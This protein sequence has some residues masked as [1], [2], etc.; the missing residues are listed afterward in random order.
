MG[1]QNP[2]KFGI[3]LEYENHKKNFAFHFMLLFKKG[4][5]F[6]ISKIR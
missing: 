2:L 3:V 6:C 4:T 5:G 1:W